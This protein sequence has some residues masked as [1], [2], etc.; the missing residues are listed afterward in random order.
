MW[1]YAS[2]DFHIIVNSI[3]SSPIF[4]SLVPIYRKYEYFSKIR[5]IKLMNIPSHRSFLFM[6]INIFFSFF[7]FH[8]PCPVLIKLFS[9]SLLNVGHDGNEN[10]KSMIFF[11]SIPENKFYSE[12]FNKRMWNLSAAII[13]NMQ[14]N[15]W[16]SRD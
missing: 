4:C 16:M 13:K 11:H 1:V 10:Y 9:F 8:F 12:S 14:D 6:I 15:C 7:C 3:T 2:L 5:V